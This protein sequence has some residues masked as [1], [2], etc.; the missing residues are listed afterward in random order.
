MEVLHSLHMNLCG[1]MRVQSINGKKYMLVIIDDYL[2]F[3]WVK[4][5]RSK[6][7]TLEF[8][9]KFLKQI[10]VG[11]NKTNGIVERRNRTLVEVAWTMLIFSKASDVSIG[12]SCFG[13][14]CYPTNDSKDLGKLKATVDIGIFVGYAPNRKGLVPNPV[15]V[16]CYVPPTNKDL[17]MLFQPICTFYKSF[18]SS[19]EVQAPVLHQGV[20]AGPTIEDNPYAQAEDDPFVNVF[21]PEPS[22]EESSSGDVSS[23]E[24]YQVIQPHDHLKKW[25][26]DHPIDNVIGN[27]S[28][29]FEAMQDEIDEFDRLQVWEL[30]P[31]PD[32]VMIISL[33][34]IY[35]VKL[36][37]Y[38]DVLK[39]KAQLVAK[40]Y[41]QEE[42]IDFKESFAPVARIEAFRIF[43][44]NAVSKNMT[45]YQMDVK[46]AFLNEELKRSLRST[47]VVSPQGPPGSIAFCYPGTLLVLS[48][49]SI[50]LMKDRSE[51]RVRDGLSQAF[52][53]GI[54]P[55]TLV[56]RND[57]EGSRGVRKRVVHGV[58]CGVVRGDS[59]CKNLEGVDSSYVGCGL[60]EGGLPEGGLPGGGLPEGGLP[61]VGL[62]GGGLPKQ[63]AV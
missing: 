38:G 60:P 31:K 17:E 51:L 29:P 43:I 10:H 34:W 7:E 1:P 21:A 58:I 24:S 35:K 32:C 33:K 41:H 11:L 4:F 16:A 23:A 14:L 19:S 56:F 50:R 47:G 36:D 8:V 57:G 63:V 6:D 13:A 48:V 30:V 2:R 53:A 46:T 45:I 5:L 15:L 42:G 3:T 59:N 55:E 28:R 62:L 20:A 27:P 39:N 9:I 44:A 54:H 37:E 61:R 40:G 52:S 49:Q 22:S 25:T 18:T 26:K 12:R